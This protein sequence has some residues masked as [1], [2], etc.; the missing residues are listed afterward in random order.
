LAATC[1]AAKADR[2]RMTMV[3]A[4]DLQGKARLEGRLKKRKTR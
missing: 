3:V 4:A 2:N 1:R